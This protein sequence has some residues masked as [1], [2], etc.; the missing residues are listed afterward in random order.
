MFPVH[1]FAHELSGYIEA[2]GRLF[3]DDP[4]FEGQKR[5]SG[6]FAVEPDYYHEWES[7]SSFTFVP[8]ARFDSAD[9]RR[10]HYD[11]R[12]LNYLHLAESWELRVGFAKVFW[13]TTEF[14]H[15]VDIINQ[16][17]LV[18][19]IDGE[20]KLGQPM[21]H[22]SVPRDWGTVDM[23][24]M[25]W[26]RERTFPG[27]KGRLRSGLVVDT[28]N[29]EYESGAKEQHVDFALRYS[30]TI[31]DWD[32]GIYQF[33]G[34]G[35]EPTLIRQNNRLTP[36]YEQI[37]QTGLDAQFV[38]GQWL[39]KLESI[40]RTGQGGAFLAAVGGFEYTLVGLA[41]TTMDL[42]IIGEYAYDGRS[43][44]SVTAF[45][46]DI[47]LGTRLAVND[48]ASSELLFGFVQDLDNSSRALSIEASRRIGSNWKLALEGWGF[49]NVSQDDAYYSL[50]ND[51]YLELKLSYYF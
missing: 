2:E 14:L 20:E 16:T 7:G 51:D 50:R 21:V 29:P 32:F 13:G 37:S 31:G 18:E 41:D 48:A 24:V 40:Y 34:T 19:N 38:A 11:I 42:G 36:F 5:D 35:R 6:S 1:T 30:H 47:M 17:D 22:L 44:K 39:W 43:G 46:N 28:G 4:L 45:D 26:F 15:L 33:V 27:S 3:F 10:T 8:F 49:F 25:P 9:S 12:E 23:F